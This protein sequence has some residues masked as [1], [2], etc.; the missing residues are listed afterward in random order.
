[1]SLDDITKM[2]NE[3]KENLNLKLKKKKLN[4]RLNNYNRIIRSR[5]HFRKKIM[6][7]INNLK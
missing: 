5:N 4:K 3:K 1:M 2:N 6:I 7:I